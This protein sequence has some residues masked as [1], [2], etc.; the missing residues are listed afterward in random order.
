MLWV[1]LWWEWS[2]YDVI[3]DFLYVLW[4]GVM[5]VM[6]ITVKCVVCDDCDVGCLVGCYVELFGYWMVFC[7]MWNGL[8]GD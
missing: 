6:R 8:R 1:R 7:G 4:D 5:R 3:W 2:S